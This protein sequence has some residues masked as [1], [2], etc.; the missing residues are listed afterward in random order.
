M[1][2]GKLGEQIVLRTERAFERL[3]FQDAEI[4]PREIY[5]PKKLARDTMARKDFGKERD[6]GIIEQEVY[7]LDILR[8]R[9][10]DGDPRLQRVVLG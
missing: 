8:E 9:W 1:L 5:Y 4:T 7:L 3:I 6:R 10:Q 2:L